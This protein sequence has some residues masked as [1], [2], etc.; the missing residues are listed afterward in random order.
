M[1]RC[2]TLEWWKKV[3]WRLIDITVGNAWIIFRANFPDPPI[4]SQKK[5]KVNLAESLMQPL[6]DLMAS[7]TCP[8]YLRTAKEEDQYQQLNY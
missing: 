3:F 4:D 6:L 1:T 2:R 8:P 7:P 5:F